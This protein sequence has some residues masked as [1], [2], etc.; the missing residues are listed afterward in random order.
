VTRSSTI[1]TALMLAATLAATLNAGAVS[2]GYSDP[3]FRV[4]AGYDECRFIDSADNAGN[5][6]TIKTCD[7]V[8]Y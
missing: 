2:S 7:V 1:A 4:N 6:L 5:V 8:P 3:A